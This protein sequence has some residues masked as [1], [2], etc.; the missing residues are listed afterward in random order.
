M[1][2]PYCGIRFNLDGVNA[3][4]MPVNFEGG[5]PHSLRGPSPGDKE[6]TIS[7]H[8][9]PECREQIMWLNELG[10]KPD[11]S[12]YGRGI[13]IFT[14]IYPK[15]AIKQL[16]AGVPP[17]LAQDFQEA[18]ATRTISPKASA[19]LS[20]RC[21]Q[22]L[23]REQEGIQERDLAA[24]ISA[25]L[26]LNKLPKPLAEDLDAIRQVGNFAAH[27]IKSTNTGQIMEVEPEEADWTLGVLE[28]L[29]RFYY[30]TEP[31]SRH[32]RDALNQKLKESGKNP[33]LK[34]K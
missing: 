7:A 17:H 15:C 13:L 9:C 34:P 1:N 2:C 29:I 8:K 32:R 14:L 10:Q 11:G 6:F 5:G 24:E 28:D 18:Y 16:P 25:L 4:H 22:N 26:K 3:Y 19:A 23:I 30:E 27:P 31:A 12:H 20:R 21:L 33:M